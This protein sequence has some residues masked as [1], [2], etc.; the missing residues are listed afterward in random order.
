MKQTFTPYSSYLMTVII[1]ISFIFFYLFLL[2]T[3]HSTTQKA[4][5]FKSHTPIH[6]HTQEKGDTCDL[7]VILIE[8]LD[9][10]RGASITLFPAL[11]TFDFNLEFVW[12]AEPAFAME[13]LLFPE[14]LNPIVEIPEHIDSSITI[15]YTIVVTQEPNC[16]DSASIHINI[17]VPIEPTSNNN[18]IDALQICSED[19]FLQPDFFNAGL[20][21][22]ESVNNMDG[23]LQGEHFSAWYYF[24]FSEDMPSGSVL[25]FVMQPNNPTADLDFAIWG[26][27]VDCNHLGSPVRCSFASGFGFTTGMI[28][29]VGENSEG[30]NGDGFVEDLTVE[31]GQ[32][33]YFLIDL[34]N[35]QATDVQINWN[36]SAASYMR[37]DDLNIC[38]LEVS[39]PTI[40]LDCNPVDLIL[41]PTISGGIAPYTFL[42]S[43]GESSESIHITSPAD[44]CVT[45]TDNEDCQKEACVIFKAPP[46]PQILS[47]QQAIL[48]HGDT[49]GRIKAVAT[50]G[51]SPY[52]YLWDTGATTPEI[53]D[54][55][56]GTY[57]V[58]IT[59]ANSCEVIDSFTISEPNALDIVIE[60][61]TPATNST[62]TDGSI[63]VSVN[64]GTSPYHFEWSQ[65]IGNV[66]NP[67]NLAADT[68]MLTVT[69]AHDC[70]STITVVVDFLVPLTII[71]LQ[72]NPPSCTGLNNGEIQAEINGGTPPY[73]FVWDN[74][75]TNVQNP[76]N[77]FSGIYHVT[78]TD[79]NGQTALDSTTL[80]DPNTLI[81]IVTFDVQHN[82]GVDDHTGSIEMKILG[83]SPTYQYHWGG[84][85]PNSPHISQL[86]AGN[87]Q[88]TVTDLNGC[89]GLSEMVTLNQPLPLV[90]QT[91][92]GIITPPI[93]DFLNIS[94]NPSE[95]L[96]SIDLSLEKEEAVQLS[97]FNVMGQQIMNLKGDKADFHRFL[98]DLTRQTTGIYHVRMKIGKDV[99]SRK[100]VLR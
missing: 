73:T 68:Y 17:I 91:N 36:G 32:G 88:L 33:Y 4:G 41:S 51:T 83:N 75:A 62:S 76:Q 56:A 95:G 14:S 100:L 47:V 85:L 31:P 1:F 48:C 89:I 20:N 16:V 55:G 37:C 10:I 38:N 12:S 30:T 86:A 61:I 84:D 46:L 90:I 77:L 74:G 59:D 2:Q 87:Y 11:N 81:Q 7:E 63:Q 8:E 21:D 19:T 70:S 58:T 67:Q 22:F 96:F 60:N 44:Y 65:G 40:V 50:N 94:P 43:T 5:D 80:I 27:D 18:C 52:M 57:T 23:C 64:G 34:Y 26:A 78:V 3:P 25:E 15:T 45:V 49:N 28:D 93:S 53:I 98:V 42:W 69:D 24:Q 92:S 99:I 66:Q 97:V 29:N 79:A 13:Y 35:E 9:T 72:P 39:I 6:Y 54:L 71:N 82:T